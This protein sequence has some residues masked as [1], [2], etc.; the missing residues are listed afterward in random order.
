LTILII[1][2]KKQ[3]SENMEKPYNLAQVLFE[4]ETNSGK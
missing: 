2:T 4:K 3:L 1:K